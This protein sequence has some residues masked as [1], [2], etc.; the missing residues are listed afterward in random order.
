VSNL[1][2]ELSRDMVP[3]FVCKSQE[4]PNPEGPEVKSSSCVGPPQYSRLFMLSGQ[5]ISWSLLRER[6][7]DSLVPS[8]STFGYSWLSPF[9]GE[10]VKGHCASW[11]SAKCVLFNRIG[12]PAGLVSSVMLINIWR[13]TEYRLVCHATNGA[14]VEIYW[15]YKELCEC[16]AWKWID[17]SNIFHGYC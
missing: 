2:N 15:T 12:R 7:T 14:H 5:G 17:F 13:E 3:L 9:E 8:F 16:S 4:T 10:G 6:G 11:K 1:E